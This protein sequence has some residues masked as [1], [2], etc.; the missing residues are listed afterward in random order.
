MTKRRLQ[1]KQCVAVDRS[2]QVVGHDRLLRGSSRQV[3]RPYPFKVTSVDQEREMGRVE[4]LVGLR[5]GVKKIDQPRLKAR[6]QM[7]PRLVQEQN[8]VLVG[9]PAFDEERQIEGQ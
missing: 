2:P 9:L 1:G 4:D 7:K 8:G 5:D 3:H 6:M